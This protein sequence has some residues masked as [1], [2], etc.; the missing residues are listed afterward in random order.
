MGTY[1]QQKAGAVECVEALN[2]RAPELVLA[3]HRE[4]LLA[5]ARLLETNTFSASAPRLERCG[6]RGMAR[7]V[8]AAAVRLA[9]EAAVD[10]P[11]VIVA[12]SVGPLSLQGVDFF[13]MHRAVAVEHFAG[14]AGALFEAGADAVFL[15]TLSSLDEALLALEASLS[16]ADGKP[17]GVM[18]A[19]SEEGRLA[20]G[21]DLSEAF[22]KLAD[23][24]ASVLGL[25]A[26]LGPTAM[27]R[28][29]ENL[30]P[31]VGVPLAAFPN[32][33]KPQYLDGHFLFFATPEYFASKTAALVE[34]GVRLLGGCIGTT[35][36]HIRALSARLPREVPPPD[37]RTRDQV[38]AKV[39]VFLAEKRPDAADSTL[40][41]KSQESLLDMVSRRIT[42]IVELDTPKTLPLEK[43]FSAADNLWKTGADFI[44]LAD[45]ALAILRNSNMAVG[46]LLRQRGIRPLIH[47]A[48]R[49]KNLIAMQ[50]E[51]MGL[52]SLG[53][54]HILAITGDPAKV[55]DHPAATS[56]YDI[57][58]IGL[59]RLAAS[60][61]A[62]I[63]HAGREL[64]GQTNFVIGCSFNPNAK[65]LDNQ[66]KK[67]ESKLAA[68][69]HYVMTQPVF[70]V[71]TVQRCA[72]GL[73]AFGVPVFLGVMPIMNE[74]NAEFLHNEVPGISIPDEVR[75]AFRG[76]D[77]EAAREVSLRHCARVRD[78][79]LE[80][81]KG[82]YL[83]TPLLRTDLIEPLI[84]A[85]AR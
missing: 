1:L 2:L 46:S 61:N 84:P 47:L 43:Y 72:T 53:L 63:S 11:D 83:I 22:K 28:L 34:H 57:N 26:T 55:G 8:N 74:K 78:A 68:G 32:A 35:P 80:R 14:H 64:K 59:I 75:E 48:C 15:E 51:L 79:I 70:D 56:V 5:G 33:G 31:P 21:F 49:D 54:N 17:V 85:P 69:A 62:G 58:S 37:L 29:F 77:R 67:L 9:R 52:H 40:S 73:A 39:S 50:S 36:D 3:A 60:F 16:V 42:T 13:S 18:L 6:M 65:N 7:E 45:N 25:N 24:G 66:F 82:L 81:F 44:S 23:N 19:P 4:Y 30:Q 41:K 12:G 38:P 20:G 10:M 76:L 27:L 71:A